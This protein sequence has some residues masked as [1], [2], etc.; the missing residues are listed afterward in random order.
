[1]S[2]E[3][4]ANSLISSHSLTSNLETQL[5]VKTANLTKSQT[6]ITGKMAL[7]LITSAATVIDN[8]SLP[9]IGNSG[10]NVN[11]KV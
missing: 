1:M 4:N 2:V 5:A 11:I 10:H 7:D 3:F 9:T 6:E 8:V